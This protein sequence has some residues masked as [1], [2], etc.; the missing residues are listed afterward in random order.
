MEVSIIMPVYNAQDFIKESIESILNQNYQNFELIII[1]DGSTDKT[2]KYIQ[3]YLE[4]NRIRFFNVGRV[5]KI[6]A[7]IIVELTQPFHSRSN[8]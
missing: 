8:I 3:A 4:D 5:G 7:F 2:H 1:N 6:E